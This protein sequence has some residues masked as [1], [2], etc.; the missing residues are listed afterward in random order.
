MPLSHVGLS[1]NFEEVLTIS[2]MDPGRKSLRWLKLVIRSI[3]PTH[4]GSTSACQTHV[5]GILGKVV[6]GKNALRVGLN[7]SV[8]A[9]T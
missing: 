1:L 5:A 4:A 6:L 8:H 7:Q 2:G 3:Q 9:I